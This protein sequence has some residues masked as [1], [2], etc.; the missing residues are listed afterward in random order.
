EMVSGGEMA[1]RRRFCLPR[2]ALVAAAR[3][4]PLLLWLGGQFPTLTPALMSK[5]RDPMRA[6]SWRLRRVAAPLKNRPGERL[7]D[8]VAGGTDVLLIG[9]PAEIRPFFETGIEA[10]RPD[11]AKKGLTIE[12][13]PAL[14][15]SLLWSIDRDEV[16]DLMLEHVVAR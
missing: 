6:V 5:M 12:V 16:A 4:Q 7:E 3:Q 2:T 11:Q 10:D 14:E 13:L 1:D 9:G 15:H 8:L